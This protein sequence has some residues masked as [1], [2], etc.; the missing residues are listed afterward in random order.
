MFEKKFL[1]AVAERAIKTFIQ[2]LL[3]VLGT[4]AVGVLSAD[5]VSALQI[6]VAASLLSVLTSFASANVGLVG[7]SLVGETTVPDVEIVT[8]E[9][10]VP[11]KKPTAKKTA[12]AK[13]AA[14][15][16]TAK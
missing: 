3:A 4:D 1:L 11:A 10:E 14:K 13:P 16:P 9:V 8:V 12:A 15:K 2:A 5:F 6:S 7:P